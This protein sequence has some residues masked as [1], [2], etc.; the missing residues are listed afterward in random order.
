MICLAVMLSLV[1]ALQ[2]EAGIPAARSPWHFSLYGG[3]WIDDRLVDILRLRASTGNLRSSYALGVGAAREV[4]R[5]ADPVGLELEANAAQH[6]GRQW[7]PEINALLALRW[8]WFPWDQ[9]VD[10]SIAAGQGLSLAARR[11]P[12]ENRGDAREFLNYLM[13]ELELR[14]VPF[15][16][17]S[18]VGRIHHR[19]GVFGL[20]G[21]VRGGSNF[22]MIGVRYRPAL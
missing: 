17:W 6:F 8:N 7:H 16:A 4:Y 11:P 2:A 21:G 20:Y 9:F 22:L 13:F 10:T 5:I 1:P 12:I 18:L 3:Q 15:E 19:S 14:P